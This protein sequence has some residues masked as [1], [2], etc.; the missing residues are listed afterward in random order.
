M[1][2]FERCF[3]LL[4]AGDG[5]GLRRILEQDPAAPG[6]RD[7]MGVSLLM[8]CLYRGQRELAEL[9]ASKKK[10]DIFEAA[11][12]GRLDRLQSCIDDLGSGSS[13][14]SAS[15]DGF[16]ALHFACFFGQAEAVRLLLERGAAVDVV[17]ANPT[18]VMALHS[19][20]SARNLEAARMLVEHGAPVNA[21]QQRGWVPIHAAA[22]NG[23]RAMVELL[24]AQGADASLA[25]DAGKTAADVAREKGYGEIVGLLEKRA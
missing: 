10:L 17:A 3:E 7:A 6:A 15:K 16:T 9:I 14:D 22:Q 18:R 2:D 4:K 25:N 5:D 20:A 11:G 24:L 23:D 1:G 8:Q 13:I 12:L 19:A 21:R